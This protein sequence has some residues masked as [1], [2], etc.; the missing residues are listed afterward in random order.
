MPLS[1]ATAQAPAHPPPGSTRKIKGRGPAA[2]GLGR[3]S[4][5]LPPLA[6][7]RQRRGGGSRGPGARARPPRP[8]HPADPPGSPPLGEG[9][10]LL[11]HEPGSPAFQVAG[12]PG[13]SIR[14]ARRPAP[15]SWT[16]VARIRPRGTGA[17]CGVRDAV[18]RCPARAEASRPRAA[19]V[20]RAPFRPSWNVPFP[21]RTMAGLWMDARGAFRRS[22]RSG[23]GQ[24]NGIIPLECRGGPPPPE[25]GRALLREVH[26]QAGYI[27]A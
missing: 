26:V 2:R 4:S 27:C 14:D 8:P 22:N 19:G 25:G 12:T 15:P 16:P 21:I 10:G 5:L 11:P 1:R 13:P 9:G 17:G 24:R 23:R 6:P 3:S 18:R 20:R 7:P